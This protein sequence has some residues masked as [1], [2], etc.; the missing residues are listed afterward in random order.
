MAW[1]AS[2]VLADRPPWCAAGD[3][4]RVSAGDRAFSACRGEPGMNQ[5]DK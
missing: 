5:L 1:R 3:L 2:R 4:D